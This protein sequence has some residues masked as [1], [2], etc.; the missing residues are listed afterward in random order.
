[1]VERLAAGAGALDA[2]GRYS[3]AVG[4]M[5]TLWAIVGAINSISRLGATVTPTDLAPM[6]GEAF[7]L[8]ALGI[9][10]RFL[11]YGPLAEALRSAWEVRAE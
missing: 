6:L 9:L 10:L 1:P 11:V 3:L 8:P 7:F 2:L 4:V 5:G